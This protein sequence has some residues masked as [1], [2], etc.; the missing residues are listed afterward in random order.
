MDVMISK[1]NEQSNNSDVFKLPEKTLTDKINEVYNI[2]FRG[3]MLYMISSL[4]FCELLLKVIS[5]LLEQLRYTLTHLSASTAVVLSPIESTANFIST[6]LI[7]I[8][9][10]IGLFAYGIYNNDRIDRNFEEC[11]NKLINK[12]LA[13]LEEINNISGKGEESE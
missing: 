8:F 4:V 9:V 10:P 2:N 6:L 12:H 5:I 3:S 1:T 13:E 11:V 7:F